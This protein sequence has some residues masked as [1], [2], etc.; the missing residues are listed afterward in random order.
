M[1]RQIA[2]TSILCISAL[3]STV[4]FSYA[5]SSRDRGYQDQGFDTGRSTNR[6]GQ[7]GDSG[8]T[9]DTG[10]DPNITP[11]QR[12]CMSL[13]KQLAQI[14]IG[15]SR[16]RQDLPK[17]DEELRKWDQ[18]FIKTKNKAERS[19]CYKDLFIFGKE[20]RKTRKCQ[21]LGR[22]IEEARTQL[23]NLQNQKHRA[24]SNDTRD[25]DHLIS[26]LAR[27]GCGAQYEREDRKRNSFTS[28]FGGRSDDEDR[29]KQSGANILPF[30]TYRTMC[31]RTCDGFYFPVSFSTL[32]SR[33]P[34]DAAQC[35]SKCAAPAELYVYK[36]P[37]ETA[38]QMISLNGQLYSEAPYAFRYRKEYVKGCS[39]KQEEFSPEALGLDANAGKKN[40]DNN[41]QSQQDKITRQK[42]ENKRKKI[43]YIE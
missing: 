34:I 41:N 17:L 19:K 8:Y 28:I 5:Q 35:L 22:K 27:E 43:D 1:I 16:T 31:I 10:T 13:E 40:T 12:R 39:C 23:Q 18:V 9:R 6:S 7:D 14:W 15:K 36:N 4:T 42:S 2:I 24:T 11:Q 33:F 20:L 26:I 32:P 29:N 3:N 30:A 38:E 25:E 21:K 37:G